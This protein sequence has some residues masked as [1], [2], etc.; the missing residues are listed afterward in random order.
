MKL[1]LKHLAPYLPYGL[2]YFFKDKNNDRFYDWW[3]HY[4]KRAIMNFTEALEN[5]DKDA[6]EIR[7]S[8]ISFKEPFLVWDVDDWLLGCGE[9]QLG[10]D[11]DDL[12]LNEVKPI[13]RPLSDLTKEMEYDGDIITPIYYRYFDSMFFEDDFLR[14]IVLRNSSYKITQCSYGVLQKLFEWHFDVFGLI[15]KGLAIDINSLKK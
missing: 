1:E 11:V 12:L 10:W 3:S 8:I 15:E 4:P 13:L 7:N 14:G 9:T 6:I 2:N 5:K